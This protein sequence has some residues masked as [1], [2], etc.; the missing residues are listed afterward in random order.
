[1]FRFSETSD[2]LFR[3]VYRVDIFSSLSSYQKAL[4]TSADG[5]DINLTYYGYYGSPGVKFYNVTDVT[6]YSGEI[7]ATYKSE[8]NSGNNSV[9]YVL[10]TGIT[11]SMSYVSGGGYGL[12]GVE[13]TDLYFITQSDFTIPA[14]VSCGVGLTGFKCEI[15]CEYA[16]GSQAVVGVVSQGFDQLFNPSTSDQNKADQFGSDMSDKL[17]QGSDVLEQVGEMQKPDIDSAIG[18]DVLTGDEVDAIGSL[19]STINPIFESELIGRVLVIGCIF[20][21]LGYVLFGKR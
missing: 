17:Q 13:L 2:E 20:A 19:M 6:M 3:G 18:D 1:M 5:I 12:S 11:E 9:E 16:D 21:L 7:I 14:N 4:I 15:V 10:S 8:Y